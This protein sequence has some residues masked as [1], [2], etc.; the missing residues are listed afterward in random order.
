MSYPAIRSFIM[1]VLFSLG[2]LLGRK[3]FW[4]NTLLFAAV[5]IVAFDPEALTDL[6]FQLSFLASLCIGLVS[7]RLRGQHDDV[8]DS[9]MTETGMP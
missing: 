1:I 9:D 3:G 8:Q 2:L 7:D 4:L 5:L 6:S